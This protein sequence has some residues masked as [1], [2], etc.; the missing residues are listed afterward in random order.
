MKHMKLIN[1]RGTE[2][3]DFKENRIRTINVTYTLAWRG[4]CAET[5]QIELRNVVVDNN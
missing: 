5:K 3:V 4:H 1:V 2:A